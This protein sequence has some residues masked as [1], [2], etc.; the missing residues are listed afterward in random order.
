MLVTIGIPFFNGRATLRDAI[1]SV[2][3]QTIEDWELILA[4]D[5]SSDG[6][7]DIAQSVRDPRVRVISDGINRG[8]EYRHNQI[9]AA[10]RGKYV[11]KLDD[12]DLMHPERLERQI[13]YLEVNPEADVVGSSVYT[14]TLDDRLSGIRVVENSELT[15]ENVLAKGVLIQPT[16]TGKAEWFQR[17]RYN[18]GFIRAEDHEIWCRTFAHS[19]FRCMREPLTFY[20]EGSSRTIRKYILSGRS[21]RRIFAQYGPGIVGWSSTA[22]LMVISHIKTQIYCALRLCRLQELALRNSRASL[23]LEQ[24]AAAQSKLDWILRRHVPGF[25]EEP[26]FLPTRR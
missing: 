17:N 19:T 7:L 4:D 2:F 6:S 22:R 15:H 8:V 11:A 21:D 14:V 5:G 10:A 16:V 26:A 18:P 9:A 25:L 12:D 3:A 20:R 23:E 24:L 1:R 13:Q